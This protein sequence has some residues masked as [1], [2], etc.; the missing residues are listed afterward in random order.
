MTL[1][2]HDTTMTSDQTAHTARQALSRNGW[3]VSWLPG[4]VLDRNSAIT[5]MILA[6]LAGEEDLHEGHRLW[7]HIR[8]WAE[9]LGLTGPEAVAAASQ[10]P[11]DI[12]HER[13]Q[14]DRQPDPEAA[15]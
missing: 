8:G 10:P 9:E 14:P 12:K 15:D 13:E 7:P 4:Q 11:S 2:I 3:E 5:A 6:D 1:T